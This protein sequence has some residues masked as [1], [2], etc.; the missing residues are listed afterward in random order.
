[1]DGHVA[2]YNFPFSTND[3]LVDG[4]FYYIGT[5]ATYKIPIAALA[6]MLHGF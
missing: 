5:G 3:I 2:K 6:K 1:M 4:A